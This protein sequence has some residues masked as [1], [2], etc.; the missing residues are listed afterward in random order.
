M[1]DEEFSED[2]L[3]ALVETALGDRPAAPV[4]R[5]GPSALLATYPSWIFERLDTI[6][7]DYAVAADRTV[8]LDAL[9][10]ALLGDVARPN[11]RA[12][13]TRVANCRACGDA[14]APAPELPLYNLTD[15]D[16]VV[17][18][19]A[20]W[21]GTGGDE[22]LIQSLSNAGFR[23]SRLAITSIY[24]CP[25]QN[26]DALGEVVRTC[27][28]RYLFAELQSLAP[29]LIIASGAASAKL[30][31]GDDALK[32]TDVH[33]EIFWLGAFPVLVTFGGGYAARTETAATDLVLDLR[34]GYA[35]L[36]G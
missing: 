7:E 35:Y 2:A 27:T 30:I 15:P 18:T 25:L 16:A 5:D 33:G 12:L 4:D 26:P 28:Q 8:I 31:L 34:R 23:S 17:V 9:R 6:L 19:D 10:D 13:H 32:I 29:R 14:V 36:Y 11:L 24:R 21:R 3:I 22:V 1:A 20:P